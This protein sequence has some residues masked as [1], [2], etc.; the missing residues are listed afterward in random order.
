M[1]QY[2]VWTRAFV[3]TAGV[4][5]LA[6]G[7]AAG[8]ASADEVA[9][10]RAAIVERT[11]HSILERRVNGDIDWEAVEDRAGAEALAEAYTRDNGQHLTTSVL[12]RSRCKLPETP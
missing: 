6:F 2:P 12:I 9:E 8:C 1:R 11:C 7:L 5:T 3:R 10:D 4:V